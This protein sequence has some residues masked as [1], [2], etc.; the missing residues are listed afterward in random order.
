MFWKLLLLFIVV[1]LVEL[2][3]LIWIG[4]YLGVLFTI[5]LVVLTA[6]VGAALAKVQGTYVWYRILR[7][8]RQGRLPGNELMD[9]ALIFAAGI[10]FLTPG[11]LTDLAGFLLLVPPARRRVR[12]FVKSYLMKKLNRQGTIH[13]DL[14]GF[15]PGPDD[16]QG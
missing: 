4:Q 6:V 5:G 3:L 1:P 12:E 14:G 13:I 9:G 10:V 8:L 16:G 11:F 15:D 2:A 7:A